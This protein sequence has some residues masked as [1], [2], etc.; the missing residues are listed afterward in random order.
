MIEAAWR[1]YRG[2]ALC[3]RNEQARVNFWG[4]VILA[5]TCVCAI[6]AAAASYFDPTTGGA[7]GVAHAP[8]WLGR[9]L[10]FASA[11]A[12]AVAGAIGATRLRADHEKVWITARGVAEAIKSECYMRAAAAGDYADAKAN[13]V[14]RKRLDDITKRAEGI[15]AVGE[16]VAPDNDPRCPTVGMA[17]DWYRTNRLLDQYTYY[18]KAAQRESDAADRFKYLGLAL[19]ALA[20]VLGVVAGVWPPLR[21]ELWIGVITTVTAALTAYAMVDRRKQIASAYAQT[22]R[23]LNRLDGW[24]GGADPKPAFGQLVIDLEDIIL[25]ENRAWSDVMSR[26]GPAAP[27]APPAKEPAND[28]PDAKP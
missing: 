11:A 22:A 27:P 8:D 15:V 28:A 10:S 7:G 21:A 9:A 4:R 25:A 13:D 24:F 6:L 14:L 18:A 3:S 23:K 26:G 17:P 12:A 1:E 16:P 5:L 19:S 20:A 2:W